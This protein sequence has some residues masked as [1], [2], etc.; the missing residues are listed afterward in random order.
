V[1]ALRQALASRA[2]ILTGGP[3]V[4][5]TTLVNAM[6]IRSKAADCP[7]PIAERGGTG[8][9]STATAF[10]LASVSASQN[11]GSLWK[12][13]EFTGRAARAYRHSVRSNQRNRAG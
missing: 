9:F 2:L 5:K 10:A 12:P 13:N 8:T 1:V 6:F 4:G 7:S 11:F 3:G